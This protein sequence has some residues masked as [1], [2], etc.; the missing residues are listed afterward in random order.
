M[1]L[2]GTKWVEQHVLSIEGGGFLDTKKQTVMTDL[3][4]ALENSNLSSM[5]STQ[6]AMLS[7]IAGLGLLLQG[8]VAASEIAPEDLTFFES[9]IRPALITHCYE[10]HSEEAD[11]R[12]GGLWLDR[13]AGWEIGGDSGPAAIAGDVDGSLLIETIRYDDPDLEMPPDGK[14]PPEI[15]ADFE[16]W[17]RRGLPDPRTK[18]SLEIKP[19]GMSVE[20][21][22]EFWSFRP[23]A[24][25]FGD[26]SKID[27]FIGRRLEDAGIEPESS[28][29]SLQR[30]RRT[31]IDL[32]GLIPTEEEQEEIRRDDSPQ[33]WEELIDRWL[34][35]KAFGE[36]WGRHWLDIVRYAD[37]SGG[38]RA[39]PFPEA[40]RFRDHIIDSFHNDRPLDELITMHLAGDLLPHSSD[41][42]RIQQLVSTGFLVLGPHNYENQ[43]KAEL[44]FEIVD[45]QL[46]TLGRA[47]MGQT[48]GCARCHDHKFDPV[49]TRDYYAM[50][51]ILLSSNFVTH[52]NVSKWH[53]EPIPP[54]AEAALAIEKFKGHEEALKKEVADLKKQLAALGSGAGGSVSAIVAENLPGLVVDDVDAKKVGE[55]K[56]ST[57]QPRWVG[58]QYIHDLNAGKGE[59]SVQFT[60]QVPRSGRYEI[61]ASYSASSNRS[62]RAAFSVQTRD[63]EETVF[64]N[65]KLK[66]EHDNLFQTLGEYVLHEG[67]E[68][69]VTASNRAKDDGVVIVDA[70]QWLPLD[71][72]LESLTEKGE[73]K[74]K[75]EEQKAKVAA[76]QKQISKAE[77]E[78]KKLKKEAPSIPQAMAVVDRKEPEISGTKLRIRG[79]ESNKGDYVP[80]G[81]L[82]VAMWEEADIPKASSGRLEMARWITDEQNP[83]TARV[84]ANRIWLHLMGEGL[85]R[86][87]DNFGVTGEVP[88]HPELLDFLAGELIENGWSTKA[89]VRKIVLSEV[90]RRS[91]G[92]GRSPASEVDP[93]N[94]LYWRAHLRPVGAESLR[95]AML[96]LSG[97]LDES[98]GGASLPKGFRSEFGYRFTSKRRSVY[99]PVFRNS[100]N[101]MFSV[102]DFANPNFSVG[103]RS[104]STIPTQALFLTNHPFVHERA[105]VSAERLLAAPAASD[106]E[107]VNLLYRRSLGREPTE[108]EASLSIQFLR[109]SGDLETEDD[110]NAWTALQRALFGTVDFRFL[111]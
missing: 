3:Q 44:N 10:C 92:N 96:T 107:R 76:L 51:G 75:D 15:V 111:R 94:K 62:P 34:G 89:L 54:G 90:Y 23:R 104:K 86:T 81:F 13:K 88:T 33:K 85:V 108:T 31:K 25:D 56:E 5:N 66:P 65:Q 19:D 98:G 87:V 103:K 41:E 50:A 82:E 45:E 2:A 55:W 6:F 26:R 20:E 101:E 70:I 18:D 77:G 53:M 43:N 91:T 52:S 48:F 37:S 95:D 58:A 69:K 16:E 32:T 42:E 47:F 46:D 27:D 83:L 67:E 93:E 35:S 40:W 99:V 8:F 84:L 39:M 24:T 1:A 100:G 64:V 57:S 21:G 11:K 68:V 7:G 9:K 63:R 49:P 30:L 102:F 72:D 28:A 17:V 12:K 71:Q 29:T 60:L 80:R 97:E 74:E 4:K 110:P 73:K 109:E 79:V 106:R 59:K 61:R 36:R 105:R 14:L 78:I 38:G 22:R